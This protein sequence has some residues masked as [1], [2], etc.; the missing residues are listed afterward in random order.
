MTG[1]WFLIRNDIDERYSEQLA[2][3]LREFQMPRVVC[4][5]LQRT[6]RFGD[7][8]YRK[9][10]IPPPYYAIDKPGFPQLRSLQVGFDS[11]HYLASIKPSALMLTGQLTYM[12]YGGGDLSM[13]SG[14]TRRDIR[15]D[16]WRENK[17]IAAALLDAWGRVEADLDRNSPFW[18]KIRGE[19]I[20]HVDELPCG[21]AAWL[22]YPGVTALL[23]DPFYGE[24]ATHGEWLDAMVG[25]QGRFGF[26]CQAYELVRLLS[27]SRQTSAIKEATVHL[28][29]IFDEALGDLDRRVDFARFELIDHTTLARAHTGG[30]LIGLNWLLDKGVTNL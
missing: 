26:L 14:K 18:R 29:R 7:C 22:E 5:S 19:L 27:A 24:E 4:T 20:E 12:R 30:A 8:V 2:A 23:T 1:S 11:F 28:E 25:V 13:P 15:L 17:L 9:H 10:A 3:L 6:P 16:V 21:L